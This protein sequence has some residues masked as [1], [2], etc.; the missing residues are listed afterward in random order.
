MGVDGELDRPCTARD[1]VAELVD[2][3]GLDVNARGG[4]EDPVEVARVGVRNL[5]VER[6]TL[7]VER[8][9]RLLRMGERTLRSGDAL[10]G[11]LRVDVEPGR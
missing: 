8:V 5:F 2:R 10:P 7:A 6:L 3:A 11:R 4:E 9:E 1:E